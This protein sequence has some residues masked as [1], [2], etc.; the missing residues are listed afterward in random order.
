MILDS[1]VNTSKHKE[2]PPVAGNQSI[3]FGL[4][5]SSGD[6]FWIRFIE[7]MNW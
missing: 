3:A 4:M 5:M 6:T 1:N 7:W 2:I